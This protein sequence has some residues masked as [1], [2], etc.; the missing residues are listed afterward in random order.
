MLPSEI[1][2]Y[3]CSTLVDFITSLT[4]YGDWE[5]FVRNL[6][7]S[8]ESGRFNR[9]KLVRYCCR[10]EDPRSRI[11]IELRN[12]RI[13]RVTTMVALKYF[14][15]MRS[16]S[17]SFSSGKLS[18][19]TKYTPRQGK[20]GCVSWDLIFNY[21]RVKCVAYITLL[22]S[23]TLIICYKLILTQQRHTKLVA[24]SPNRIHQT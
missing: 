12:H 8:E 17:I 18:S 19:D 24:K 21:L 5:S 20:L 22:P 1:W 14:S 10:V 13:T 6:P 15:V 9:K 2:L 11:P 16:N 7:E 23:V 4:V 3:Y